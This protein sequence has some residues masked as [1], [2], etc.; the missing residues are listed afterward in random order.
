MVINRVVVKKKT[1]FDGTL[2]CVVNFIF[3]HDFSVTSVMV[4]KT[5]ETKK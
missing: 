5:F 3:H 1:V 4:N 2:F